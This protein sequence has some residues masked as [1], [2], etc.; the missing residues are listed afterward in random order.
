MALRSSISI[1]LIALF[2][3]AV[4]A[5]AAD[6]NGKKAGGEKAAAKKGA[7]DGEA[8]K[9]KKKAAP[10][11]DLN[12]KG[13]IGALAKGSTDIYEFTYMGKDKDGKKPKQVK[14]WLKI[15]S[16]TV[17]L[18]DRMV[19]LDAFK[20]GEELKTFAK[21]FETTG[22]APGGVTG[23]YQSL[24]AARVVI[25][26][27]KVEVNEAYEDAKDKKFQWCDISIE[28]AGVKPTVT[29]GG[30]S[31]QISLDKGAAVIKREDGDAKKDLRKGAVVAV[32]ASKSE[33]KPAGEKEDRPSFHA[34]Q[35]L[36]LEKRCGH[37]DAI[38]P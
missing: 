33:E 29:Y 34:S 26:G 6:Q 22:A 3:F 7:D 25:G 5:P 28:K 19:A 2:G 14:G 23:K 13:T 31:Y 10:A 32:Q 30:N 38:L 1:G 18:A 11:V 15:D 35:L 4:A 8:P 16:G 24:N 17:L 36:V 20:E 12:A 9:K 37:Y 27:K 21:P